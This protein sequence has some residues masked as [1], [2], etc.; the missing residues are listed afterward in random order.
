M[1][2]SDRDNTVMILLSE[3]VGYYCDD[4]AVGQGR[5]IVMILPDM[6]GIIL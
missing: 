2:E 5:D 1:I 6:I 4:L 3:R